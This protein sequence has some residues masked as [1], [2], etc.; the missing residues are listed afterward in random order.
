V[1]PSGL[2]HSVAYL[3]THERTAK[4]VTLRHTPVGGS[5]YVVT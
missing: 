2:T 5:F 3:S 4:A 1:V